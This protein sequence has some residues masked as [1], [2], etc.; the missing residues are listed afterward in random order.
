MAVM[1]GLALAAGA[2]WAG[3]IEGKVQSFDT[4]DRMVT[5]E[6]GTKLWVAEGVSI[7]GLKEGAKVK[8]SY[9]ERDGKNVATSVEVSE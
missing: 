9:E 3:D 6:D 7:E 4:N 2:A 1:L 8:A 5:L